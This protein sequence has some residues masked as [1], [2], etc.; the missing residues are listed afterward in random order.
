M[1][2]GDALDALL[3]RFVTGYEAHHGTSPRQPFDP[4]WPSPC[5]EGTPDAGDWVHWRPI[6]RTTPPDFSGLE[7]AL[8]ATLHPDI[9]AFFGRYYCEVIP[10]RTSEGALQLIQIWSDA[11]FDRLLENSLGHALS[12]FRS[13][14]PLS[15]FIATTD[16][17]EFFLAV[18]N[19]TGRVM[20]ERPGAPAIREVAPNLAT[21][22]NRIEPTFDDMHD[23][24]EEDHQ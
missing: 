24:P 15:L 14:Q 16:E 19:A 20:L 22:L 9:T 3:E 23:A 1:S 5:I 17:D 18:E 2:V 10:G 8:G 21:L 11:D 7:T 13:K 12:K 6:R 4:D